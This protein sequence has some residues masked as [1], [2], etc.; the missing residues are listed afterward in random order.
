MLYFNIEKFHIIKILLGTIQVLRQHGF[1]FLGPPTYF[2]IN[3]TVNQQKLPFSHPTHL[4]ADVILEWS[5]FQIEILAL[6]ISEGTFVIH[7]SFKS[8]K[9][10]GPGWIFASNVSNTSVS[11]FLHLVFTFERYFCQFLVCVFLSLNDTLPSVQYSL[12]CQQSKNEI[13]ALDF[14]CIDSGYHK[15]TKKK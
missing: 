8:R 9:K 2:S 12:Y 15:Q 5:L 6:I 1:G 4:Y 7:I 11:D 14:K 13:Q 3:S 10:S